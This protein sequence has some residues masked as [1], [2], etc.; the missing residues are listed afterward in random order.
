MRHLNFAA[1]LFTAALLSGGIAAIE[2]ADAK[3]VGPKASGYAIEQCLLAS[4]AQTAENDTKSACCSHEAGICVVC[5][6]PPSAG[7]SCDVTPY[8]PNP[9]PA[10]RAMSP[11]TLNGLNALTK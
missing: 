11:D 2:N 9:L 6:K 5:P 7:A 10:P 4:D 1:I 3:K 8:R